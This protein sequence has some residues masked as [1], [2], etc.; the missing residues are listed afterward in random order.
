MKRWSSSVATVVDLVEMQG[1]TM[2]AVMLEV[3]GEVLE[4]VRE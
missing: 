3:I 2:G 4:D 1:N